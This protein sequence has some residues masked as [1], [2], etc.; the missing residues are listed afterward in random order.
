MQNMVDGDHVVI[1]S[2]KYG[3]NNGN[4]TKIMLI[5]QNPCIL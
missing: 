2:G 1:I 5:I 4:N 3:K